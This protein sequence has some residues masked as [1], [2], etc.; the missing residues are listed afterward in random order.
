MSVSIP[1]SDPTAVRLDPRYWLDVRA[2]IVP[3]ALTL[4]ACPTTLPGFDRYP[5]PDLHVL[6]LVADGD[7][8]P[9]GFVAKDDVLVDDVVT[10]PARLPE[11]D[12]WAADPARLIMVREESARQTI[13]SY[14][15]LAEVKLRKMSRLTL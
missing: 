2:Q 3:P 4:P 5:V 7:D 13:G 12:V 15:Y 1:Q 10:D 9:A 11:L 14:L 6:D 8:H